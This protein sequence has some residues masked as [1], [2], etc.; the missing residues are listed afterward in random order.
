ET[1]KCRDLPGSSAEHRVMANPMEDLVGQHQPWS[2]QVFHEYRGRLG[3]RYSSARE[4]EHRQSI[5][6]HNMRFVH[7][8]NRAA[9]SYTLA[10]NHLA[11]RTPQEVSALRGRRWTGENNQGLPFPTHLYSGLILPESLDWRMYG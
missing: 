3:R 5:F 4:L 9:L 10:L 1:K 8:R 11:D 6:L 2:H 7:S